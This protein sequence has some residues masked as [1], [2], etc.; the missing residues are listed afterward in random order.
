MMDD[1]SYWD[2]AWEDY[3]K[4]RNDYLDGKPQASTN[5]DYLTGYA[6]ADSF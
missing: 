4:G 3:D 1:N 5:M 6:D 2:R